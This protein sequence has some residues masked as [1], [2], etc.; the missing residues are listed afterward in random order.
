LLENLVV[1]KKPNNEYETI[2][3]QYNINQLELELIQKREYVDLYGKINKIMLENSN[4]AN[5]LLGKYYFNGSCWED[6]NYYQ[7][8]RICTEGGN[9]AYAQCHECDGCGVLQVVLN[10]EEWF[11]VLL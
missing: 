3:Y 5:D 7:P 2:I 6:Y 1:S 10:P 9:H 8:E 11:L 4:I